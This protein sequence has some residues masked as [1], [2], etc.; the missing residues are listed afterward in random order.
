M[1]LIKNPVGLF[2]TPQ[3]RPF[4]VTTPRGEEIEGTRPQ[5]G[6]IVPMRT[7][8]ER[9]KRTQGGKAPQKRIH[10]L[11]WQTVGIDPRDGKTR[12]KDFVGYALCGAGKPSS[13]NP[14]GSTLILDP[15]ESKYRNGVY[16]SCYRCLKLHT[17][18]Q[19]KDVYYRQFPPTNRGIEEA[20]KMGFMPGHRKSHLMLPEGRQGLYGADVD[21]PEDA[22]P[23][24]P[25]DPKDSGWVIG[26]PIAR[27]Q[28]KR[29][30]N[31]VDSKTG[32]RPAVNEFFGFEMPELQIDDVVEENGRQGL[33]VALHTKGTADVMFRDMTYPIRRQIRNLKK[34]IQNPKRGGVLY[35]VYDPTRAQFNAQVQA[36]YE[37]LVKKHQKKKSTAPFKSRGKRID[38]RMRKATVR[39]LLNQ[40]FQIATGVGQKHGYLKKGTNVA[41]AKGRSRSAARQDDYQHLMDNI[42]DYETTLAMSRQ[43]PYRVVEMKR[44]KQ[45][46]YYIMPT[47]RYRLKADVAIQDVKKMNKNSQGNLKRQKGIEKA[48]RQLAQQLE[49]KSKKP[50]RLRNPLV[51]QNARGGKPNRGSGLLDAW[52]KSKTLSGM[53]AR[54][55]D[56]V[57]PEVKVVEI[58][59]YDPEQIDAS[60][61]VM[62]GAQPIG[63]YYDFMIFGNPRLF[64]VDRDTRLNA[65]AKKQ[66][67]SIINQGLSDT[68]YGTDSFQMK[69]PLDIPEEEKFDLTS[70]L[71]DKWARVRRKANLRSQYTD[72]ERDLLQAIVRANLLARSSKAPLFK[73][74]YA[75]TVW[76]LW[77][78]EIGARI[79]TDT[80]L[81]VPT[82]TPQDIINT[83]DKKTVA[84]FNKALKEL[85]NPANRKFKG[86]PT[87]LYSD[88]RYSD[89]SLIPES[90]F[91]IQPIVD[92]KT[93]EVIPAIANDLNRLQSMQ[94]N[95]RPEEYFRYGYARFVLPDDELNRL[96][97]E[98]TI[99]LGREIPDKPQYETELV[100]MDIFG[101][102]YFY[103]QPVIKRRQRYARSSLKVSYRTTSSFNNEFLRAAFAQIQRVEGMSA[104][105]MEKIRTGMVRRKLTPEELSSITLIQLAKV[106]RF[107]CVM[108][109]LNRGVERFKLGDIRSNSVTEACLLQC[110]NMGLDPFEGNFDLQAWKMLERIGPQAFL[111]RVESKDVFGKS[112][113]EPE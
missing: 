76:L 74:P 25:M 64:N 7:K 35:E 42:V 41:T 49:E 38:S 94:E 18:N 65:D 111:N 4:K 70:A 31:V 61:F 6:D 9:M 68:R 26:P 96:F 22:P 62:R 86:S 56:M 60:G 40:A 39:Q 5:W 59:V 73:A 95:L 106:L 72:D 110:L 98:K 14:F 55:Q 43:E 37:S 8:P 79:N 107:L 21:R 92:P 93:P 71:F 89:G 85:W 100:E 45:T 67:W 28:S 23:D 99:D 75:L 108:R 47:M 17:L 57:D 30:A 29:P 50:K 83:F 16:I 78:G 112:A 66:L 46:R 69:T 19:G 97:V 91:E 77:L 90:L 20:V 54:V 102:K 104:E 36:I 103:E 12:M 44:G 24:A 53:T 101:R 13:L 27:T 2:I 1:D 3:M 10:I 11:N 34:V 87:R 80:I 33:V 51:R 52:K 32:Q 63:S 105:E 84:R 109:F 48:R 15:L 81:G 58:E 113:Q 82:A 88:A